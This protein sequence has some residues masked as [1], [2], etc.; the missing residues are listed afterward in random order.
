MIAESHET[1]ESKCS[2]SDLLVTVSIFCSS[3][4]AECEDC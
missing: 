1:R 2:S 4:I 3:A